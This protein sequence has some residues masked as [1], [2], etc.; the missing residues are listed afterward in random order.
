[1]RFSP[2]SAGAGPASALAAATAAMTTAWPLAVVVANSTDAVLAPPRA[3]ASRSAASA[4]DGRPRFRRTGPAKPDAR[5]RL[6]SPVARR[7]EGRRTA[8][9][10]AA[11]Q[12]RARAAGS[13]DRA[14]PGPRP[15]ALAAAARPSWGVPGR[16]AVAVSVRRG[17][18]TLPGAKTRV[19]G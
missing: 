6:R 4:A 14:P 10:A 17:Y 2:A 16:A 15:Q 5:A 12:A 13:G 9:T 1:M 8:A 7:R 3:L 19:V 18:A 11:G